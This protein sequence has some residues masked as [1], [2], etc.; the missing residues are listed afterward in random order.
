MQPTVKWKVKQW[1]RTVLTIEYVERA[2]AALA[3]DGGAAVQ[4]AA[5]ILL[6]LCFLFYGKMNGAANYGKGLNEG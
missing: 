5:T 2:V 3:Y 6:S 4:A 1:N